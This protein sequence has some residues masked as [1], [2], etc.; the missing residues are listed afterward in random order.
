MPPP[1]VLPARRKPNRLRG[2]S[3]LTIAS[4]AGTRPLV[5]AVV[6]LPTT[7]IFPLFFRLGPDRKATIATIFTVLISGGCA[8]WIFMLFMGQ[9]N[10]MGSATIHLAGGLRATTIT[11]TPS[12]SSSKFAKPQWSVWHRISDA[13]VYS[14]PTVASM[15]R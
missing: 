9:I 11:P 6:K 13:P 14:S 1:R 12:G 5:F 7:G 10:I 8:V 2:F 3:P 4:F 15:G